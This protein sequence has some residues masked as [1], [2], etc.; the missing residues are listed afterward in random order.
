MLVTDGDVSVCYYCYAGCTQDEIHRALHAMNIAPK[1]YD[2]NQKAT[3]NSKTQD[4]YSKVGQKP[5]PAPEEPKKTFMGS[6]HKL[7]PMQ[8]NAASL[9]DHRPTKLWHWRN[10]KGEIVAATVRFDEIDTP[11]SKQIHPYSVWEQDGVTKWRRLAPPPKRPMFNLHLDDGKCDV[12]IVE[13][14][15]K[16]DAVNRMFTT[17]FWATTTMGGANAP[18]QSDLSPLKNRR[19]FILVDMDPPGA[20]YAQNILDASDPKE[21]YILRMPKKQK[22]ENRVY[23]PRILDPLPKGY[24]IA[25]AEEDGWTEALFSAYAKVH[26]S[27]GEDLLYRL[28]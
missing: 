8:L 17:K 2:Q 6:N 21:L 1:R 16:V 28:K 18:G 9:K 11:N 4:P 12:I 26:P 19:V 7:G 27:L 5:D 3:T 15:K 22:I 25:D 20:A 10:R 14:E 24:D 13:G 23:R